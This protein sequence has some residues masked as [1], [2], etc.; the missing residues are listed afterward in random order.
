MDISRPDLK[1]KKRRRQF[2]YVGAGILT[3]IAIAFG[4]YAIEPAAP[5]VARA[6]V[7]IDAVK[8]GEMKREVRGPG[9]LVP[10]DVR[11]IA[12]ETA[13]RVDRFLVKPGAL[14]SADTVI[15]E[16]SNPE[17][18]DQL[19]AARSEV[20]AAEADHAALRMN[21]ESQA[22]DQR[23][24][25]AGIEADYE[26]AR[27]QAEAEADL[28]Q[29]GIISD[30]NF[31]RSELTA[32]RLKVRLDIEQERIAKFKDTMAAQ[33]AAGRARIEQLRNTLAL[34]ERQADSLKLKAG[35]DGVLQQVPVEVGQQVAP[36]TNLARVARPDVLIAELRI[37]ET[38]AKD[39]LVGQKVAVDTR[40]GIVE[41]LVARIDPA[42]L[43]GTVQVDVD[44]VGAL[45][46]GARPDLSIDGTIEIERLADVL[47][48]GRP[49]YGQP[50]S[51]TTLFRVD[52][53]SGIATR[54]PVKLGRASVTVIEVSRGL[55]EGDQV[56]LSDTE[57]WDKYDRLK[58][59]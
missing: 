31:R 35:I 8:R 5:K 20:T 50:Q 40:N 36:G 53:K 6:Q 41:G 12:A 21:L 24:N 28:N 14:V 44:L 3:L 19:L 45:P 43:N 22:L 55:A 48:V 10:K 17:V 30:I 32:E 13:A 4:L 2:V 57:Q 33:L 25:M 52:A 9:T 18:M 1:Q 38:Q 11:W 56:V 39:V 47:Y 16:L 46:A 23:A 59:Q 42:V 37:P 26:S 51:D 7:W 27:L 34:R 58:L 49:A 15:M 54:V 29:K